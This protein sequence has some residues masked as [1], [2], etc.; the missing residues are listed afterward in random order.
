MSIVFLDGESSSTGEM[1]PSTSSSACSR[2]LNTLM[3]GR[4]VT[5]NWVLESP[6]SSEPSSSSYKESEGGFRLNWLQGRGGGR[7][8]HRAVSAAAAGGLLGSNTAGREDRAVL[9]DRG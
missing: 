6:S 2:K 8:S 3:S 9:V 5:V 4:T 1:K 7:G